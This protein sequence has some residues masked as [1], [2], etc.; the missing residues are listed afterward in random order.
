MEDCR[1]T[2][3][4]R[5][6]YCDKLPGSSVF[7]MN[8]SGIAIPASILNGLFDY[9]RD[10]YTRYSTISVLDSDDEPINESKFKKVHLSPMDVTAVDYIFVQESP[11]PEGFLSIDND[12]DNRI[13]H[14][15]IYYQS[16]VEIAQLVSPPNAVPWLKTAMAKAP[17]LPG[18][19]TLSPKEEPINIPND[20]IVVRILSMRT[21]YLIREDALVLHAIH[22]QMYP[23]LAIGSLMCIDVYRPWAVDQYERMKTR[24]NCFLPGPVNSDMA[25]DIIRSYEKNVFRNE[26]AEVLMNHTSYWL[27]NSW[28]IVQTSLKSWDQTK[29]TTQLVT[30]IKALGNIIGVRFESFTLPLDFAGN[31]SRVKPHIMN[32]LSEYA[33]FFM[34]PEVPEE[35]DSLTKAREYLKIMLSG[36]EMASFLCVLDFK[37]SG[38]KSMA[39]VIPSILD[40]FRIWKQQY[41]TVVQMSPEG[42]PLWFK[43]KNP[44]STVIKSDQYPDLK[45]LAV[46][47]KQRLEPDTWGKFARLDKLKTN[48]GKGYLKTKL[49]T[50]LMVKEN[51]QYNEFQTKVLTEFGIPNEGGKLVMETN[52]EELA[53]MRGEAATRRQMFIPEQY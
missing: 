46:Y 32:I 8:G 44:A 39:H 10:Q 49:G 48:L 38:T 3:E 2:P 14:Y 34:N 41:D 51:Y 5:E 36:F 50:M 17:T 7:I 52:V 20:Q 4:Q 45:F 19:A 47:S 15:Q 26:K 37:N 29:T 27:L 21:L 30:R 25:T 1:F 31:C 43:L 24:H 23:V 12:A 13:V 53:R 40:Q 28:L 42:N 35:P 11:V 9:E 22:S 33:D 16:L 18:F 6:K